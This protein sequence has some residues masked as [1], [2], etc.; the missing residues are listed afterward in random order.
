MLG[1]VKKRNATWHCI[2]EHFLPLPLENCLKLIAYHSEAGRI[3]GTIVIGE[4]NLPP[5]PYIWLMFAHLY[6]MQSLYQGKLLWV[7]LTQIQLIC[8]KSCLQMFRLFV[9][10]TTPQTI[11]W[12]CIN[13]EFKLKIATSGYRV[14]YSRLTPLLITHLLP[15][16]W[17]QWPQ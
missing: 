2:I 13:L 15:F 7:K 9:T 16:I 4:Q 8:T 6:T 17:G 1:Q 10:L 11:A 14:I 12:N 3:I 5:I